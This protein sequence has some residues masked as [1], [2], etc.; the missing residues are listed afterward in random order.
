MFL[1]SLLSLLPILRRELDLDLQ[2]LVARKQVELGI[3]VA[4]GARH[5]RVAVR[6]GAAHTSRT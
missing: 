6:T 3:A 1:P 5:A 2:Q 4:W